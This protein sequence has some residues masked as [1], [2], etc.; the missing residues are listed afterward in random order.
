[1]FHTPA[2][3]DP[4]Q[5]F[6]ANQEYV[7]IDKIRI[8]Y[9]AFQE[10]S[11]GYHELFRKHRVRKTATGGVLLDDLGE[12]QSDTPAPIYVELREHGTKVLLDFNPARQMDPDGDTLCHPDVVEATVIWAIKELS[13]A[14]MPAWGVD[15]ETGEFIYDDPSRWPE[16]WQKEVVLTR[17]DIA[18][19]FYSPFESFG[20]KSLTNIRKKRHRKDVLHRN[21][22]VVQ[23]MTWGSKHS[24]R[25]NLYN[26]SLKHHKDA[27]GGWFRFEEQVKTKAL[28]QYGMRTLDGVRANRAYSLLWERWDLSNLSSDVTIAEGAVEFM[29][30]L[31]NATSPTKA[32]TF[33]GLALSLHLG[34]PVAMNDR[35]IDEYRK[36]GKSCGFTLGEDP[37]NL[38]SKKVHIDFARGEVVDSEVSESPQELTLTDSGLPENIEL[39]PIKENV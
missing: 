31:L 7:G 11:D 32:Q 29:T 19:D 16:G 13:Y 24:I 8:I 37:A 39:Q 28:K 34:L 12:F 35:T 36:I 2:V 23:T 38:G 3:H 22:E 26:K 4:M 20:V 25:C 17:L 1:M 18:R 5:P 27:K 14:V 15:K 30:T 21:D 9:P 33:M 6:T 10:Y